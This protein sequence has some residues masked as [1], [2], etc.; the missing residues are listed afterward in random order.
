MREDDELYMVRWPGRHYE[1][2]GSRADAF[3][4]FWKRSFE[5][6]LSSPWDAPSHIVRMA[7][8]E[9]IEAGEIIALARQNG[10]TLP[11]PVEPQAFIGGWQ[12]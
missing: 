3:R 11:A 4:A 2:H 7:T 9:R 5:T 8:G 1:I 6:P 12:Q 10:T